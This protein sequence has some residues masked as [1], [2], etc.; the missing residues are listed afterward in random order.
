[1]Q[2]HILANDL[3]V[4]AWTDIVPYCGAIKERSASRRREPYHQ[5]L[6]GAI[7]ELN[8]NASGALEAI[9]TGARARPDAENLLIWDIWDVGKP[10]GVTDFLRFERRNGPVPQP[11]QDIGFNAQHHVS[12][13]VIERDQIPSPNANLPTVAVCSPVACARPDRERTASLWGKFKQNSKRT[14][15]GT[16]KPGTQFIVQ[17]ILS[18]PHSVPVDFARWE[19][20]KYMLDGFISA[21]HY[22]DPCGKRDQLDQVSE[23]VANKLQWQSDETRELL[24]N[25]ENA[26]L[27]ACRVPHLKS[28]GSSIAWSPRD[29]LLVRAEI[30]RQHCTEGDWSIAG[31]LIGI[32]SGPQ[33]A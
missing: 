18:G 19:N 12:Y 4:Q 16:W 3:C 22:Y 8:F 1:M 26:V 33:S 6:C 14:D 17:L 9:W 15:G 23:H 32:N 2:H 29:D 28:K 31:R 30:I 10:L 24:L 11:P 7:R 21:L 13:K 27:G 25:S 20:I 5:A